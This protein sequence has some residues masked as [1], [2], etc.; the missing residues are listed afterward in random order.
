MKN[1]KLNEKKIINSFLRDICNENYVQANSNLKEIVNL[2]LK[3]LIKKH[4]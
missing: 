4:F 1:K 3:K 2:K